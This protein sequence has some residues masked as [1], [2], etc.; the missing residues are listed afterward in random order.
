MKKVVYFMVLLMMASCSKMEF[1]EVPTNPA[2]FE[3]EVVNKG[4]SDIEADGWQ[5]T[6]VYFIDKE[7]GGV[8]GKVSLGLSA[9]GWYRADKDSTGQWKV[10]RN[11]TSPY[12]LID[13]CLFKPAITFVFEGDTIRFHRCEDFLKENSKYSLIAVTQK[14]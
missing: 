13:G 8:N 12:L 4:I 5:L 11:Y 10:I 1:D 14:K 7:N 2:G 9:D 6:S 3:K